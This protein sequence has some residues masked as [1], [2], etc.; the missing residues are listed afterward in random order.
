MQYQRVT[1]RQKD[2]RTDGRTDVQPIA[3]TCFSI[4]DARKKNAKIAVLLAYWLT[5]VEL[6]QWINVNA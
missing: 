3:R 5:N 4:A 1:D 6:T 2:G